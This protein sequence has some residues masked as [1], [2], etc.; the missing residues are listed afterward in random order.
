MKRT[1]QRITDWEL[2]PFYLIYTPLVLVWGYYVVRAKRFWFFA[3]VNPSLDF[4]GFEGETKKEMFEQ[5]SKDVYPNTIYISPAMPFGKV[6]QQMEEAGL[7]FPIAVKPDIGTKGLCFRKIDNEEQ[8]LKYH[9][10]LP[11][12]YVLQ[13]MIEW[14][15]ELSVF[16][17]RYPNAPKG[18]VTGFIAKEY[19][20]VVGNGQSTLLQL[21]EAHPRAS[22]RLEELTNKHRSSL[23]NIIPANHTYFLSI[24]GNHNRGAKFINLYKEIDADL[25]KVFDHISNHTKHFYYGRYD[26]KTTSI[27]DLK[28][29]KN[30]AVLEFNGVGAEPNHIYDCN[31]N[32]FQ[33][34]KVIATHWGH[35]YRIGKLNNKEGVPYKSFVAGLKHLRKAKAFYQ[36]LEHYDSIC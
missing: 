16:Y 24:T 5:L 32:Y 15:V 28:R 19:L 14:P 31:M 33:A 13:D 11:V 1:W 21:M 12:D 6:L 22:F 35:M 26:V 20:H 29:G 10:T 27:E 18:E 25:V 23:N 7:Q 2:W 3:P 9:Q 4:S 36:R 8:L 17:V 30:I 34:L